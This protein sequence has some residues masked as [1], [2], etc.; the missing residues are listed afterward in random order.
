MTWLTSMKKQLNLADNN[1][2]SVPWMICRLQRKCSSDVRHGLT[3][4]DDA[5]ASYLHAVTY[6]CLCII[7]A[8]NQVYNCMRCTEC[9]GFFSYEEQMYTLLLSVNAT[10]CV[11]GILM[12]ILMRKV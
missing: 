10:E 5:T 12:I 11:C 6:F 9:F 8:W 3:H 4:L 7:G 1:Y 2:R